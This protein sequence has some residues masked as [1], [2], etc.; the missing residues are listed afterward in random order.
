MQ[1]ENMISRINWKHDQLIRDN[2]EGDY[3]LSSL[4]PNSTEY[5]MYPC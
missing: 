1:Y 5:G 4:V 2:V 3:E